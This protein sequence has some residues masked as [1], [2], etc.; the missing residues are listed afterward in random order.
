[1]EHLG[2]VFWEIGYQLILAYMFWTDRL[3]SY[4]SS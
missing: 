1:M 4:F 2:N 3:L